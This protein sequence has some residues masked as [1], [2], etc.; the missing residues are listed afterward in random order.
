M[1]LKLSRHLVNLKSQIMINDIK[2]GVVKSALKNY[3]EDYFCMLNTED[4]QH[5]TMRA[6]RKNLKK[7]LSHFFAERPQ[8][9]ETILESVEIALALL[10]EEKS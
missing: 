5:I 9:I 8:L 7:M 2:A 6:S 3:D 1:S 10:E 4:G